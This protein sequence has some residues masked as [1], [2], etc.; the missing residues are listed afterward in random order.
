MTNTPDAARLSAGTTI[1]LRM[2]EQ[3]IV[4]VPRD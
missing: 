4:S 3:L 2:Q 1:T